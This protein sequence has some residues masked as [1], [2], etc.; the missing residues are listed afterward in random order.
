MLFP[1][2]INKIVF[3]HSSKNHKDYLLGIFQGANDKTFFDAYPLYMIREELEPNKEHSI[4]ISCNHKFQY[5][6]YVK[7]NKKSSPISGLEIYGNLQS[8]EE[9]DEYYQPTNI[10]LLIINS[11]NGEMPEGRDKITR[12]KINAMIV[13]EGKINVQQTGTIKLRGN[14]H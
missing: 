13:N 9:S 3:S 10:P 14:Y 6:R 1:T 12:V 8:F 2:K 4:Q 11:E 5:I 7:P